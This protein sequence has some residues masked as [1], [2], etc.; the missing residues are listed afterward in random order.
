MPQ[1]GRFTIARE[2]AVIAVIAVL[3]ALWKV[4]SPWFTPVS[5]TVPMF[6]HL[7]WFGLAEWK[8]R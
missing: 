1:P 5:F 4:D 3:L 8:G 6:L 2:M 7:A